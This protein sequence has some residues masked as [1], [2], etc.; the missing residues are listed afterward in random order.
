MVSAYVYASIQKEE[1][2]QEAKQFV[3]G[4]GFVRK[5]ANKKPKYE[6]SFTVYYRYCLHFPFDLSSSPPSFLLFLPYTY[7]HKSATFSKL[8]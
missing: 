1:I 2:A 4:K 6:G 7:I 5:S 8:W 3:R